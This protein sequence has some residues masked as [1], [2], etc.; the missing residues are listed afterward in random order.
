MV[1]VVA[2]QSC[3]HQVAFGRVV[4]FCLGGVLARMGARIVSYALLDGVPDGEVGL[5][6]ARRLRSGPIRG[7]ASLPITS[8]APV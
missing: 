6:S 7:F 8:A 3:E 2:V 1:A 4:P 5:E